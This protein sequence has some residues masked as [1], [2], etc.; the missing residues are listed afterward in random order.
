[1]NGE[2]SRGCLAAE[3]PSVTTS[4]FHQW[5]LEQARCEDDE[6]SMIASAM[7]L[8]V[9]GRD[10]TPSQARWQLQL[11]INDAEHRAMAQAAVKRWWERLDSAWRAARAKPPKPRPTHLGVVTSKRS[12][13]G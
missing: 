6:L 9:G 10:L 5:L 12:R 7:L 1:M 3:H 2:D 11:T 13:H 8:S 4:A